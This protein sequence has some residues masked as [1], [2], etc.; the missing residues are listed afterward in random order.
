MIDTEG[1]YLIW[2]DFRNSSIDVKDLDDR[3]IHE[4]KLWLDSGKI[5]GHTGEGFERIHVA[6]PRSILKEALESAG[7]TPEASAEEI[8][9]ALITE[10]QNVSYD[11]LTGDGMSWNDKGEVSK[12]PK[13]VI[14][15]DGA[16]A[17]VD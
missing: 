4:A 3:I 2:L 13:A 14:I 6:C 7:L 17:S 8:C 15:K 5:F 9:E 10:I 1:T 12:A 11:G 16:Y